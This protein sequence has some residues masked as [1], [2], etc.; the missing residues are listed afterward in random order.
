VIYE[1]LFRN[2][3]FILGQCALMFSFYEEILIFIVILCTF[4]QKT[5]VVQ[6]F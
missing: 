4:I 3:N 5:L 6:E 1:H 2:S